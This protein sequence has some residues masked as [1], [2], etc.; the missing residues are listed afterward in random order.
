MSIILELRQRVSHAGIPLIHP[1]SEHVVLGNVFGVI[2]NLPPD[3]VLNPWLERT[4]NSSLFRS[5][6]WQFSFWEKQQRPIGVLEGNTEVDLLLESEQSTVFVEVKM[7]AEASHSTKA[8]PERNQLVRNLDV[9][10]L[11]ATRDGK[12][13]A[14]IYVTPDLVQPELVSRLQSQPASFP[15]NANTDDQ[16]IRSCLHWTSWSH[17]GDVVAEPYKSGFLND[18]ERNFALDVLAYLCE[19]R[20]WKSTLPDDPV[21]Y[22]DKLYRSLQHNGSPF[23][24]Y[25]MQKRER[26]QDWRSKP[27]D[28]TALRDFLGGLALKDKALLKILADAG[29]ALQQR[30]IMEKLPFL[31][32]KT[33]ASLRSAKAHVNEGCKQLDCAPILAEGSGSGDYRIHEI[34]PELGELRKVVIE[35]AKAFEIPWH[36]LEGPAPVQSPELQRP[37][38]YSRFSGSHRAWYVLDHN[39]KE[40][41]AAF[42][43]AKGSC[44]CRMYDYESGHFVRHLPNQP[45][46]SFRTV[47][48]NLIKAGVEF[49]PPFQPDLVSTEK[50]GLPEEIVKAAKAAAAELRS[51][52]G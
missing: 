33:S 1:S 34:N 24:P 42:V 22:R 46:G 48:A 16:K 35:A 29:G 11:R 23:I 41:I 51:I 17:I 30:V 50:T 10:F 9:G 37:T 36:L 25:A 18:V 32:G 2:K 7:D 12:H 4:T 15:A 44:S 52:I 20:L 45:H 39:G 31:T 21:F 6:Q 49:R 3:A 28:M 38:S 5:D 26:Y 19:K 40:Y 14:L 43:D 8:D 13:F 27:W 47:Y